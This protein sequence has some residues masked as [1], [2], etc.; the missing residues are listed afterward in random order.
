MLTYAIIVWWPQVRVA[1]TMLPCLAIT[2]AIRTTPMAAMEALLGLL[3][4]DIYITGVAMNSCYCMTSME[5]GESWKSGAAHIGY[6]CILDVTGGRD[7]NHQYAW[8]Y[9]GASLLLSQGL[10]VKNTS[11]RTLEGKQDPVI[12]EG[13]IAIFTDGSREPQGT[14]WNIFS[15]LLEDLYILLGK[16]ASVFQAETYAILHLY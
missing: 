6:M 16:Y 3:L 8:R 7:S 9:Y 11:K 2:G 13:A 5:V 12:P 15:G 4:L 14:D 10:S 1:E